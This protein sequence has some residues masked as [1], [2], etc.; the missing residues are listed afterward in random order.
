[1][2]IT[3]YSIHNLLAIESVCFSPRNNEESSQFKQISLMITAVQNVGNKKYM[4]NVC[5]IAVQ[6]YGGKPVK[7][8]FSTAWTSITDHACWHSGGAND[9]SRISIVCLQHKLDMSR[10]SAGEHGASIRAVCGF[11]CSLWDYIISATH[12]HYPAVLKSAEKQLE[13]W[14]THES[15]APWVPQA[16]CASF[17]T[18]CILLRQTEQ[19]DHPSQYT[20][21][22]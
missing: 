11:P 19:E 18:C 16:A 4:W 5:L 1:M 7:C 13:Q 6:G 21:P 22:T 2:S 10:S 17:S 20:H 12:W 8:K 15:P 9:S 14:Q 3:S